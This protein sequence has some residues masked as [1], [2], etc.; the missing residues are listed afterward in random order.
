MR[1]KEFEEKNEAELL[2]LADECFAKMEVRGVQEQPAL[3]LQV[4]YYLQEVAR[5]HDAKVARRDF[6]LELLVIALILLEVI[7]GIAGIVYG[8]REGNEQA[9]IL[10][11]MN[12]SAAATAAT[13]ADVRKASSDQAARLK[14][15]ADEQTE[16][17]D[18]L[19]QMNDKLQA[20]L[21]QT[22]NMTAAMHEQLRI[23]KEDQASRQAQL[24]KKPKLEL[25]AGIVPLNTFFAVP[26]KAREVKEQMA[27]YDVYLKNLGDATATKGTLRVIIFA[28]DPSLESNAPVQRPYEEPDSTTHTFLMP[29]DYLRPGVTIPMSITFI[30]PR[31]QQPFTVMFNVD[32][33]ELP[34]ATPLGSITIKPPKPEK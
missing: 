26:I 24:A 34:A 23:L 9:A 22:G 31:G 12:A 33:D 7:I 20:S 8:I 10:S 25:D 16:S 28:K 29:F 15:L 19:G 5:R 4:Q 17:L 13:I 18:S 2:Q 27:K 14:A 1:V 3:L 30:Y 21:K 11:Q 6:R 32:V